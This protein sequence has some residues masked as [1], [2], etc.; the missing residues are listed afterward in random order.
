MC[1]CCATMPF[2]IAPKTSRT[3]S[4]ASRFTSSQTRGRHPSSL[5]RR[6]SITSNSSSSSSEGRKGVAVAVV[7]V[8]EVVVVEVA[9]SEGQMTRCVPLKRASAPNDTH[10][11]TTLSLPVWTSPALAYGVCLAIFFLLFLFRFLE[12]FG[13]RL[14]CCVVLCYTIRPKSIKRHVCLNKLHERQARQSETQCR[15]SNKPSSLS[16]SPSSLLNPTHHHH[17]RHCP[18]PPLLTATTAAAAAAVAGP[19]SSHQHAPRLRPQQWRQQCRWWCHWWLVVEAVAQG[20]GPLET[21]RLAGAA[22]KD[23]VALR[24][25]SAEQP[26]RA[27]ARPHSSEAEGRERPIRWQDAHPPRATLACHVRTAQRV[28]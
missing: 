28:P 14:L 25:C 19:M 6:E 3:T 11:L 16:P 9:P 18:P 23:R 12:T 8:V 10:S 24:Q 4:S 7:V 20:C 26:P 5:S 13:V 22:A 21:A 17:Q 15:S 2:S 1:K 27:A